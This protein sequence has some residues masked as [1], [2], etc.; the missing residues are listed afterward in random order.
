MTLSQFLIKTKPRIAATYAILALLPLLLMGGFVYTSLFTYIKKET[1]SDLE[2]GGF[3]IADTLR[4]KLESTM[5]M[6]TLFCGRPGLIAAIKKGDGKAVT[7]HLES[8]INGEP[9][10]DRMT[11]VDLNG[12]VL[13]G[14]LLTQSSIGLDLVGRDW[15]QGAKRTE[16]PYISEFYLTVAEPQRYVFAIGIPIMDN[17]KP[18]AFMNIVPKKDYIE[19]VILPLISKET[20]SVLVIDRHGY[21][22]Y[23]SGF[24]VDRIIDYNKQPEVAM[25]LQGKEGTYEGKDPVSGKETLSIYIPLKG[26]GGGLILE[27]SASE[28]YRFL[29]RTG[30]IFA[31]VMIFACVLAIVGSIVNVR[32][33]SLVR[34]RSVD[35]ERINE[36]V[37]K[38]NEELQQR[39]E[40]LAVANKE[41]EAFSYS[42]SHD[43]RAPLRHIMGFSELLQKS[44]ANLDE[45]NLRYL[46]NILE[47]VKR[48]GDLIDDLL[49][50]SR[51]GRAEMRKDTINTE[52]LIKDIMNELPNETK[53]R[54]IAWN[55]G[56]LP[57]VNGDYAMLRLVFTNL[58]NNA[59]KFT[60][61]RE[62]AR[63]DIG[64]VPS[65]DNEKVFF[66]RDNGAGFDMRYV[67]KLFGVFQRLHTVSEFE[68]TGIGL[69][70]VKRIVQ[71]HGGKVWAEG[72]V[73]KGATF[74]VSL[75]D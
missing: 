51:M 8:F 44:A 46:Q 24:N 56:P 67:D 75:P 18:L 43:L 42:V 27:K 2:R 64:S 15:F 68:G 69:A 22:I 74:Y 30:Y 26:I 1:V 29:H 10:I 21:L 3:Y 70:N 19:K 13:Y 53:G 33:L 35:L 40:E 34:E 14:G 50:F 61:K 25:L 23:H 63:I 47:S 52:Q 45:K 48:M 12:K 20:T 54:N 38:L 41:L 36:Q 37:R 11:I 6:G 28:A 49:S 73:D 60:R 55:T 17:K 31:G 57:P 32:L 9:D 58:V 59:I 4:K 7:G 5:A 62:E 39:I 16:K 72:A 65:G 66:V 71:R